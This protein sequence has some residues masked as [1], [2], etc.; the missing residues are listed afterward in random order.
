[1]QD[2]KTINTAILGLSIFLGLA[3]LGYFVSHSAYLIKA[4][5]R[6][7]TVKGLSEREVNAD[8]AIWPISFKEVSNNLSDLYSVMD[9][10][11]GVV[12]KYLNGKGF[13]ENEVTI[14][15]VNIIDRKADRYSQPGQIDFRYLATSTITVYSNNVELVRNSMSEISD[16]IKKGIVISED[17]YNARPEFLFTKLNEIKPEMVEEATK[18]ARSV[19]EKFAKD[20]QSELGKIK[21]ATQGLFSIYDRDSKTSYIKKVRVVTHI[22]YYLAD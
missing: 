21:S 7:V 15:P 22:E 17:D 16:L 13:K 20:S 8:I 2:K 14:S 4:S 10:K 6:F 18:D 3:V 9:E 12:M 1:M 19:A 11:S 5:E